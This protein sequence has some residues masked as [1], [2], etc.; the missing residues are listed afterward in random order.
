MTNF[1]FDLPSTRVSRSNLSIDKM[2]TNLRVEDRLDG[3]ENFRSWKHKILLIL[4]EYDLLNYV[5]EVISDP[6]EEAKAK[7]KKNMVKTKRI[8]S[9][10][11]KGHLI[12]HASELQTPKEMFEALTRLYESKNTHTNMMMEKT[13]TLSFYFTRVSH[14]K[15][16]LAT[17]EDV[18][19]NAFVQGICARRK[20]PRLISKLQKTND[21]ENQALVA[22]AIRRRRIFI[23]NIDKTPVPENKKY[24]SKIRSY[25]CNK[26]GHYA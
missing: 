18:V 19:E 17:I 23:K 12:P 13:I 8:L 1:N 16:Q 11:I 24:M 14:I 10:S 2:T 3:V 21:E 9:D 26:I 15:V 7:F 20:S 4:E 6:E 5:K 25:S 22:H